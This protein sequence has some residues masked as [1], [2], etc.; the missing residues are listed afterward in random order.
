MSLK[1]FHIIF[2]LISSFFGVFFGYWCYKEWTLY[3]DN[4]Y[5]L[6][7]LIGVLLCVGLIFYGKWFLKE[8]S[9]LN[10]S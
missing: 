3:Q 8:I 7:S 9:D 2:I 10:V 4:I 5:L 1:S 6:Y